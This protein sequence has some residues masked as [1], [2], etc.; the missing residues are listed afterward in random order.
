M[1]VCMYDMYDTVYVCQDETCVICNECYQSSA[2]EGHDVYFYRSVVGGCCD[3]GDPDAWEESGGMMMM[4]MMMMIDS[5]DDDD[6]DDSYGCFNTK[7]PLPPHIYIHRSID[8]LLHPSRQAHRGPHFISSCRDM[9][10]G[11]DD[12]RRAGGEHHPVCAVCAQAV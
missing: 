4:M 11:R 6:D 5:D 3:C 1:H 2:H 12:V 10:R 9:P 8:R 7:A